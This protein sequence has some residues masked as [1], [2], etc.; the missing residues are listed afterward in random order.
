MKKQFSLSIAGTAFASI[1]LLSVILFS[2][3]SATLDPGPTT[4]VTG[5]KNI[6]LVH[7]AFADGAG[8]QGI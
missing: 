5:I 3:T 8:W 4:E 2:S 7:G 6:V 1:A